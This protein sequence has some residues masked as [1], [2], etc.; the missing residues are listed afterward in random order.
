MTRARQSSPSYRLVA[1]AALGLLL[2]GALCACGGGPSYPNWARVCGR[3]CAGKPVQVELGGFHTCLRYAGGAVICWGSVRGSR[4]DVDPAALARFGTDSLYANDPRRAT[5]L[6]P[7]MLDVE[8]MAW[9]T[10]FCCAVRR[11]RGLWCWG[12]AGN[13][14]SAGTVGDGD[15]GDV[16]LPRPLPGLEDVTHILGTSND[17]YLQVQTAD[18][19][20]FLLGPGLTQ[21]ITA[22]LQVWPVAI[23]P[24]CVVSEDGHVYCFGDNYAGERGLGYVTEFPDLDVNYG[25]WV[26]V[27]GIDDAVTVASNGVAR[28]ALRATGE[29]WCWG[30]QIPSPDLSAVYATPIRVEAL[31]HITDLQ[32]GWYFCALREDHQLLCWGRDD[33]ARGLLHTEGH[34][35][36]RWEA[37]AVPDATDV[38][39]MNINGSRICAIRESGEVACNG[40][41]PPE[42]T[43][44]DSW[45]YGDLVPIPNLPDLPADFA[46]EP[47]VVP[48]APLDV[49]G[50]V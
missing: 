17:A 39:S 40:G 11:E 8:E 29:V 23:S 50:G 49:D 37:Y 15:S 41:Y 21:D 26:P 14:V 10:A 38:V 6:V 5:R 46:D 20:E 12:A 32:A 24:D 43:E 13:A 7:D 35:G 25:H 30:G 47:T 1:H 9:G 19:R 3:H 36:E 45:Q 18:R 28:C 31:D 16:R 4:D 27:L 33:S 48:E 2:A 34:N 22:D 44:P 42:V